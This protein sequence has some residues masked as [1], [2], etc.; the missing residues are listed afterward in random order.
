MQI[1]I[2][3]IP[4]WDINEVSGE[5]NAFLRSHKILEVEQHLVTNTHGVCWCFCVRYLERSATG[6]D[7]NKKVDYRKELD[8]ATFAKFSNLRAIRKKV[9]AEEGIS[10]FIIFTDEELSKMAKLEEITVKNMM[11]IKGIGEK[12]VERFARYFITTPANDEKSRL[13]D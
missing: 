12:K 10:A 1:K 11:G 5:M 13:P 8:E 3:T 9:A 6:T 2:F 7:E 4:T